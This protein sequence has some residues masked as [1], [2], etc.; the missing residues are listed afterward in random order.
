MGREKTNMMCRQLAQRMVRDAREMDTLSSSLFF[1]SDTYE[2]DEYL[3]VRLKRESL[4]WS[5]PIPWCLDPYRLGL[6]KPVYIHD[7][8]SFVQTY[9]KDGQIAAWTSAAE[10]EDWKII[11]ENTSIEYACAEI[12]DFDDRRLKEQLGQK[13]W[14]ATEYCRPDDGC[15]DPVASDE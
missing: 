2:K 4:A 3:F 15:I 1:E 6:D 14:Q 12:Q 11:D 7:V 9:E 10:Q 8:L 13:D 5:N